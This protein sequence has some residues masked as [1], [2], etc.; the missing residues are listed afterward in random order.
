MLSFIPEVVEGDNQWA[1]EGRTF[2]ASVRNGLDVRVRSIDHK[3][4]KDR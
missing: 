1:I 2:R 3:T 4:I